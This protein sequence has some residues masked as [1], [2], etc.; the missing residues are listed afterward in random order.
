MEKRRMQDDKFKAK[1]ALE[2]IKNEKTIS[3]LSG[4]YEI[5]PNQIRKWKKHVIEN[6]PSVFSFS[7]SKD[8]EIKKLKERE[9]MLYKQIGKQ[10]IE[11]EYLKK[12]YNQLCIV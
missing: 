4:I 3:E 10:N 2:S 11:L 1:V 12:K 8:T 6:L 7:K 9:D 5:H